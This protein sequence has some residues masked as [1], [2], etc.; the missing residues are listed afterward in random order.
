MYL[1]QPSCGFARFGPYSACAIVSATGQCN[2]SMQP[3]STTGQL[4]S[5]GTG[6]HSRFVQPT[7]ATCRLQQIGA[8]DQWNRP[9]QQTNAAVQCNSS[10]CNSRQCISQCSSQC[11]NYCSSMCV[12]MHTCARAYTCMVHACA[13]YAY[14]HTSKRACMRA[15]T[16]IC[17]HTCMC[18]CMW[19]GAVRCGAVR[20]GAV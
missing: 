5:S 1:A 3:A 19:R 12:S 16:D 15:C 8:T 7:S 20:C 17:M 14:V 4:D 6:R 2:R 11:R 18:G 9:V 10:Q 13:S